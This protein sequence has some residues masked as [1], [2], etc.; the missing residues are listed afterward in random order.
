MLTVRDGD[1]LYKVLKKR[2]SAFRG[3]K[4]RQQV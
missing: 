1:L 2:Q 4:R 3:E